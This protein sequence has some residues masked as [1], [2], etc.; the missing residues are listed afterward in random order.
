VPK[1]LIS[2]TGTAEPPALGN[3]TLRTVASLSPAPAGQVEPGT[4][5]PITGL[6]AQPAVQSCAAGRD[7]GAS[8]AAAA[9]A[10]PAGARLTTDNVINLRRIG[11]WGQASGSLWPRRLLTGLGHRQ[12]GRDGGSTGAQG[13]QQLVRAAQ[14]RGAEQRLRLGLGPAVDLPAHVFAGQQRAEHVVD[15]GVRVNLVDQQ[16]EVAQQAAG[17]DLDPVADVGSGGGRGEH[18]GG[19]AQSRS[20]A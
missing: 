14:D 13:V 5:V 20:S 3:T 10:E 1:A 12:L 9:E 2:R 18:G 17:G 4:A 11:R 16:R 6:A 19:S 7:A 15:L 8:P